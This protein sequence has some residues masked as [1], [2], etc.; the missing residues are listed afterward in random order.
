MVILCILISGSVVSQIRYRPFKVDVG[1]LAGEIVKYKAGLIMP[2]L[3][4]KWNFKNNLTFGMRLETVSIFSTNF[5]SEEGNGEYNKNLRADG[6]INSIALTGDYYF[7]EKRVRPFVGGGFGAYHISNKQI[8]TFLKIEHE[9][10]AIG[11]F[12]RIGVSIN[13]FRLSTEYN[14]I[15]NDEIN[16]NYLTFKIGFEIGGGKRLF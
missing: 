6:S 8:N 11:F 4:P 15:P 14:F 10:T 5:Q 12:P 9:F 13:K 7:N 1:V 2:Y 16:L 3:E